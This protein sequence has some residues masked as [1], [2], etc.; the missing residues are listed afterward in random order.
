MAEQHD[1]LDGDKA[2]RELRET[3]AEHEVAF[4]VSASAD[5]FAIEGASKDDFQEFWEIV[6]CMG[7]EGWESAIAAW[8]AA[9]KRRSEAKAERVQRARENTR[10]QAAASSGKT[11]EPTFAGQMA[12]AIQLE[13]VEN[14]VPAG[15]SAI[16]TLLELLKDRD[17][18]VRFLAA[19]VLGGIGSDARSAIPALTDLLDDESLAVRR[20]VTK[21][22]KKIETETT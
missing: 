13:K 7:E 22:L 5:E 12:D 19:S 20:V 4:G 17:E 2:P 15:R 21:A 16:P 14:L 18:R 11:V 9:D 3:H 6:K 8:E 1:E 10:C